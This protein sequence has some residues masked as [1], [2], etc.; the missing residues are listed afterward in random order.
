[1]WVFQQSTGKLTNPAGVV[2]GVGYSGNGADLNNPAGQG[3]VKHGPC[4]QG[5]WTI[6][7]FFDDPQKGPIVAHLYPCPGNDMDGRDGGFM[8]HGDN[9]AMNY[10]ASDGCLILSRPLREAIQASG[11]K[12]LEVVA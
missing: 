4:P 12:G 3:D 5:E 11:D 6:G 7:P 8:I 9:P 1:M 10:T 2:V